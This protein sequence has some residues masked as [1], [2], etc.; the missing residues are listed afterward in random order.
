MSIDYWL[1]SL[2]N[3]YSDRTGGRINSAP[4]SRPEGGEAIPHDCQG[5]KAAF[6]ERILVS[7]C[8]SVDKGDAYQEFLRLADGPAQEKMRSIPFKD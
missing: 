6:V 4:R 3:T 7:H 8:N 5:L 1:V 2:Q